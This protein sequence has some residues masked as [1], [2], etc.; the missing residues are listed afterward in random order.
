MRSRVALGIGLV[1][2]V[3]FTCCCNPALSQT[4]ATASSSTEARI[5]ALLAQLTID[6]KI[7]L[8]SGAT[9]FGTAEVER[10]GIHSMYFTDGPSGV[11]SNE[12]VAATAFPVGIALASSWN[13][14][15]LQQ[16]GAAIGEEVH[17]TGNH[18]LLG[19]NLNLVRSPLA[20]RNFETYGEDP[21]LAGKLGAGFVRGVQSQGVGVSA[22]HFVGNEQE[23][24]R[25]RSN[26]IIDDRALHEIYLAPFERVVNE[27]TPWTVMTAYNRVNGVYMSENAPLLQQ[28]LCKQWG[29]DGLIMSDWGGTHSTTALGAGLDLE[30]P[31]PGHHFGQRLLNAVHLYQVPESAMDEAVRRVLRLSAR[32]GA[33]DAELQPDGQV[34]TTAHRELARAAAAQSITLLK[35]D[36]QLLP[37]SMDKPQKIAVIGPN[38]DVA[39]IGGGGSA[40]VF[41]SHIVSP[42]DAIRDLLGNKAVISFQP[43]ADSE[44]FTPTIDG[45]QL[46]PSYARSGVGLLARYYPNDKFAGKAMLTR[47]EQSVGAMSLSDKVRRQGNGSI[48]VQWQGYFWPRIT[49][50]YV[51][52]YEYIR[53]V[54]VGPLTMEGATARAHLKVDGRE[55][56]NSS[57]PFMEDDESSFFPLLMRRATVHLVAGRGYP[58][59]VDYASSGYH[60]NSFK[61]GVRPPAGNIAAAVEAARAA[62]VALVFVGSG[63]T[64]ESEGR[65]R[66]SLSLYGEQD[67]LVQAVAAANPHTVVILNNGGPLAMPWVDQVPAIVDAWLPGQEGALAVADVLFGRL[68]PSGKLPVSFPKRLQDSPSYLFYPGDRDA[69]YG[70]SLFM[71]YRYYDKKQIEPLF[72]FGHGLSYTQFEYSNLRLPAAVRSGQEITVSVDVKNVG[73]RAG[74]EVAQLYVADQHCLE[75]CPVRELKGFARVELQP[76]ET[77]SVA[78]KLDGRSLAHYDPHSAEWRATPGKFELAIGSSSRDL[79]V[80]GELTLPAP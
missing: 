72:A 11:R 71:G 54:D 77:R 2:C 43:G 73:K 23:T 34:S 38:A 39:V 78:I 20:G 7:S 21:L 37:L 41:P 58:I 79:R 14:A 18:V 40:Q 46:S 49:G 25:N 6:E 12:G 69:F 3:A 47:V 76:G 57:M 74:A 75:A 32:V 22:K 27:A 53:V 66:V 80:K 5:E 59:A 31:G 36:A 16:V 64:A 15:L 44:L 17:A 45:R 13:P 35:N 61:L 68:N 70:E 26:S 60:V 24:E 1:V 33:L 19:P 9:G 55:V 42:L 52:E 10:L 4:P 48:S 51:F 63:T 65:D 50:D 67:A 30:M 29:F 56:L 8:L 62:D 28:L